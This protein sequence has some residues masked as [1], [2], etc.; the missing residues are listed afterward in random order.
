MLL[1]DKSVVRNQWPLAIISEVF[2]SEDGCVR[3]VKLRVI[4][5]GKVCEY[6]R[7]IVELVLLVK[8]DS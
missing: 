7:P 5:D 3:S 2:P 1:R 4:K 8:A 6:V